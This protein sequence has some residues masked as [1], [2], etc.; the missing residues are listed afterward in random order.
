MI[1][2]TNAKNVIAD[3]IAKPHCIIFFLLND[4][5]E[6]MEFVGRWMDLE[7]VILSEVSQ[8]QEANTQFPHLL[9]NLCLNLQT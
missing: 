5:L 1:S 4:I 7:N 2:L 6:I 3:V 8:V 9:V